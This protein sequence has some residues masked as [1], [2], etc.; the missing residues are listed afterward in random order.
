MCCAHLLKITVIL[1]SFLLA[2]QCATA[3]PELVVD[4]KK[5]HLLVKD[6]SKTVLNT[7]VGT[8]RDGFKKSM[9][10]KITPR[11]IFFIEIILYKDEA[12]N[13][14]S[15][16]LQNKY[17]GNKTASSF[18]STRA[19]L[20]R[21]FSNMNSIDF[22]G[23]QKADK[24]YGIGYLGLRSEHGVITGPKMSNFNGKPYWFSIALHTT[25]NEQKNIGSSNSGGCIHV[26]ATI[27]RQ[28][29]EQRLVG[30]GT[31]VTIN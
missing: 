4:L 10:D 20:A 5:R 9:S 30:I 27:L 28:L 17:K 18:L 21:L 2:A 14:A 13:A 1:T 26:P 16:E 6:Q 24:A 23:D 3:Q 29:I 7:S 19:G 8:G 31:R 25:N 12:F 15:R 11:G 22:D